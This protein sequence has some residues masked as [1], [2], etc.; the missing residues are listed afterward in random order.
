LKR[1]SERVA[2]ARVAVVGEGIQL[3]DDGN[4]RL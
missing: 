3:A 2:A 4:V 1:E